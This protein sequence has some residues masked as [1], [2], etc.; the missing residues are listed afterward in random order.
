[1]LSSDKVFDMLPVVV[2]LYDKLDLDTYRKKLAKENEE[3][4]LDSNDLGIEI[5]KYV[6]KNSSKVKEDFFEIVS[7]FEDKTI[8]QVKKQSFAKTVSAI[9][10]IFTDKE[11]TSFFKQ[12][13]Q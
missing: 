8:E 13:I 7:I 3:K 11:A 5:F 12:A 1:M 4:K 2:V 10:I 9:K 6:L